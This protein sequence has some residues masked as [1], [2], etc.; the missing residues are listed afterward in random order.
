[1]VIP[2]TFRVNMAVQD[3]YGNF[4]PGVEAVTVAGDISLN[5]WDAAASPLT[6]SPTNPEIYEG[7]HNVT[8]LPGTVVSYKLCSR[9]ACDGRTTRSARA[10]RRTVSSRSP[11]AAPPILTWSS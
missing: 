6:Q 10:A 4:T 5:N 3:A 8:N 7:T 11:P 1:V 2:V 9:A